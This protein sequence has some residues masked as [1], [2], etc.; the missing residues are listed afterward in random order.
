MQFRT[1]LTQ[2]STSTEP[3]SSFEAKDINH[4]KTA[5]AP[6]VLFIG[7]GN[8]GRVGLLSHRTRTFTLN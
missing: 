4:H 1:R 5:M 7:L 3:S 6:K 8:I 2:P